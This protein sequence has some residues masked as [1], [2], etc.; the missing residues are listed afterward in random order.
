MDSTP[1]AFAV[2]DTFTGIRRW[3]VAL[4]ADR[5]D[6]AVLALTRL[7]LPHRDFRATSTDRALELEVRPLGSRDGDADLDLVT[8]ISISMTVLDSADSLS[9]A[10]AVASAGVGDG[11][12]R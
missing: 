4:T 8:A 5:D 10:S 12:D 3:A 2:V 1:G 7:D 9:G 6:S 11:S